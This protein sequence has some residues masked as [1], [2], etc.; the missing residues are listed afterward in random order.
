M[1]METFKMRVI[2]TDEARALALMGWI[3]TKNGW[4]RDRYD[5]DSPEWADDLHHVEAVLSAVK[6]V[7]S[8]IED[9]LAEQAGFGNGHTS[10]HIIWLQRISQEE[11]LMTCRLD[12]GHRPVMLK[13]KVEE[14][15]P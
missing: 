2:S 9:R 13:I 6:I 4:Q 10:A 5:E 15:M 1:F 12:H 7:S 11:V 8:F 14:I 3:R